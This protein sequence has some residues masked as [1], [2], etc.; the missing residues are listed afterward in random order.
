VHAS[1]FSHFSTPKASAHTT[2][3]GRIPIL[4]LGIFGAD[5]K[6]AY[7][8]SDVYSGLRDRVLKITDKDVSGLKG[9]RVWA[10]LMDMGRPTATVTVVAIADGTASLYFSKGGG[11][12][13][14]G[15]HKNIHPESLKLVEVSAGYLNKMKKVDQ[16]PLPAPGEVRFFVVTPDGVF[17]AK[18]ME[19]E[20][21]TH[22]HDLRGLFSQTNDLIT[23]MR[24][25]EEK[26]ETERSSGA[27]R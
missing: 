20:L 7:A 27:T 15:E 25:T 8:V 10:V 26:R 16:F 9:K 5:A 19:S 11:I 2:I 23:Q 1:N 4:S 18:A 14:L 13:G 17:S 6:P 21:E 24:I 22:D 3:H 12:I